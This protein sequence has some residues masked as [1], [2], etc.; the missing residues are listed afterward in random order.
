MDLINFIIHKFPDAD[1]TIY[2]MDLQLEGKDIKAV[3]E[4]LHDKQNVKFIRG[5]P[6]YLDEKNNKVKAR[7]EKTLNVTIDE[8]EHDLI[9]LSVGLSPNPDNKKFSKMFGVNLDEN[10]FIITDQS[11]RTNIPGIYAAGTSNS[12]NSIKNS[13]INA[14]AVCEV[15]K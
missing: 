1:I 2:Y 7:F 11:G 12:P 3:Y 10:G 4:N 6:E 5:I 15:I 9:I 14:R 13:I 8:K